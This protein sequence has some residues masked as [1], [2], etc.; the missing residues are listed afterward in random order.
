MKLT[1]NHY[2]N[3]MLAALAEAVHFADRNGLDRALVTEAIMAGPMASE[4]ASIKLAQLVSRD[5]EVRAAASDALTS[6]RLIAAAA[7]SASTS[8][9]LLDL[10]S[11]LYAET[12]DLGDGREDM[13]SIIRA[14]E[15][16][17]GGIA[18]VD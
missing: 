5:Y 2:L 18:N 11:E 13:I 1:V 8:T 7:R 14:I 16:R 10:A 6:T 12:V 17:T 9:P 4:L 15:T 3:V